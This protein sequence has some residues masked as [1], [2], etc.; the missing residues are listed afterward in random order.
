MR[1]DHPGQR[2]CV[3][4]NRAFQCVERPDRDARA[5]LALFGKPMRDILGA[6]DQF[7]VSSV[8]STPPP[9]CGIRIA[10]R[11]PNFGGIVAQHR[12]QRTGRHRRLAATVAD[13]QTGPRPCWRR[14]S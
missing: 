10:G 14:R 4:Q 11:S 6:G 3:L 7:G 2:A 12:G 9:A 8:A 13:R 1:D 5:R